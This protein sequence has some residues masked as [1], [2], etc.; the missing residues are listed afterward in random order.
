LAYFRPLG[1]CFPLAVFFKVTQKVTQTFL[2]RKQIMKFNLAKTGMGY[3][4]GDFCTNSS[5][6]PASF[7]HD[8]TAFCA[9]PKKYIV[10]W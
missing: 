2:P 3:I 6:H 7:Y 1:D 5:G 9:F 8:M 4:L 10:N